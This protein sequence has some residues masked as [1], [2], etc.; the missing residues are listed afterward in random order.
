MAIKLWPCL[1]WKLKNHL[2]QLSGATQIALGRALKQTAALN[3]L[4]WAQQL[5][6]G[7]R[8]IFSDGGGSFEGTC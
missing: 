2:T 1:L 5:Y 7:G 8:F 6:D 3:P 4:Q